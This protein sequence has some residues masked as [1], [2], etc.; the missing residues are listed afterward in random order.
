MYPEGWPTIAG[1]QNYLFNGSLHRRFGYVF[2]R[3]LYLLETKI[4]LLEKELLEA[5]NREKNAD[6]NMPQNRPFSRVLPTNSQGSMNER[7]DPRDAEAV[8]EETIGQLKRY[9]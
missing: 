2:Q 3:S 4:S 6:K 7:E 8:L 9:G 5:D 1:E